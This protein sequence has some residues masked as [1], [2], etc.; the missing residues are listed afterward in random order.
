MIELNLKFYANYEQGFTVENLVSIV[1]SLAK[2]VDVEFNAAI[3]ENSLHFRQLD[4]NNLLK[5][6]NEEYVI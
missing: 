5:I 3:S 1:A 6:D 4:P 2:I